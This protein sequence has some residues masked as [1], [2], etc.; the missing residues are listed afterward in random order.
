MAI[1]NKI[2]GVLSSLR[3]IFLNILIFQAH[4]IYMSYDYSRKAKSLIKQGHLLKFE[5]V[6]KYKNVTPA[7]LLYFDNHTPIALEKSKWNEYSDI[8]THLLKDY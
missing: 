3:L 8:I 4:N 1:K 6:S 5:T 7:L 2:N